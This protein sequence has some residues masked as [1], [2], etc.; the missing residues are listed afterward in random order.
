MLTEDSRQAP[1]SLQMIKAS[2]NDQYI[3]MITYVQFPMAARGYY[4]TLRKREA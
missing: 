3:A 4:H 2:D 1:T